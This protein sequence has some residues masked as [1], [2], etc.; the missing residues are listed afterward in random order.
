MHRDSSVAH[1]VD[2]MRTILAPYT[3]HKPMPHKPDWTVSFCHTQTLLLNYQVL[4]DV[5]S[6]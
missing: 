1:S 2:I 6:G 5:P 4:F 3:V